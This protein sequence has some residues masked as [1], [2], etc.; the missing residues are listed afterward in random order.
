VYLPTLP[1]SF[2]VSPPSYNSLGW[3]FCSLG[4]QAVQ[5]VLWAGEG[6]EDAA[7]SL[8]EGAVS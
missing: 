3:A 2:P 4:S 8:W 1:T 7:E 6:V 5:L